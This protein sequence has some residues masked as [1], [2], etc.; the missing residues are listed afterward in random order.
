MSC[1]L[2]LE[3]KYLVRKKLFQLF[4]SNDYYSLPPNM[5]IT[6]KNIIKEDLTKYYKKINIKTLIIW[7]EKD[8]DTPL[9]DAKK[10]NKIIKNS[11]LITY[12]NE[13]HFSYL[14]KEIIKDINNFLNN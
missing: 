4:S 3:K 5:Y 12:K 11:K 1:L 8:I 10:L 6:F 14:N 9:K 2:P 7:G 13:N